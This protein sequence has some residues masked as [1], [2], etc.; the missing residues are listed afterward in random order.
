MFIYLYM[1]YEYIC[2][3]YWKKFF[4]EKEENVYKKKRNETSYGLILRL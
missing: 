4:L 1:T 2:V 3:I